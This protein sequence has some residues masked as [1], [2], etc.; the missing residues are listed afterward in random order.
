[1]ILY[2]R[3]E[4]EEIKK[5]TW[6]A[7]KKVTEKVRT[8]LAIKGCFGEIMEVMQEIRDA[9]VDDDSNYNVKNPLPYSSS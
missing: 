1:M 6:F 2:N 4:L 8:T 5:K 3:N 7:T 9:L